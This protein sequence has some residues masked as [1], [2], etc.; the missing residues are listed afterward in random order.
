METTGGF[1]RYYCFD[2][3]VDFDNRKD[4][5]KHLV[6]VHEMTEK[7]ALEKLDAIDEQYSDMEGFEDDMLDDE[8]E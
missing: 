8:Q 2:H 7:Q 5:A 3:E 4:A 1:S 6:K